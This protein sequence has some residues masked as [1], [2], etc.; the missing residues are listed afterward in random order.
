MNNWPRRAVCGLGSITVSAL[1]AVFSTSSANL[2]RPI[3]VYL[4]SYSLDVLS[5]S[6]LILVHKA[7]S[8]S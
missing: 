3:S 5:L 7:D 6:I 1:Q 4:S 2:K 8:Q